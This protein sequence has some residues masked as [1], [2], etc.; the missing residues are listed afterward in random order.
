[1]PRP[2]VVVT[3]FADAY[4]SLL[5]FLYRAPV[6]VVQARMDGAIEAITPLAAQFLVP[7]SETGHPENLFAVLQ[8]HVPQLSSA[9]A[10]ATGPNAV[11]CEGLRIKVR[12]GADG[13]APQVLSLSLLKLDGREVMAVIADVTKDV[14]REESDRQLADHKMSELSA[15]LDQALATMDIALA[16]EDL[17][18]GQV[19]PNERLRA[20]LGVSPLAQGLTGADLLDRLHPDDRERYLEDRQRAIEG[21]PA[22]FR[23]FRI[24]RPGGGVFYVAGRRH[25]E[26]DSHGRPV[27]LTTFGVDVTEQRRAELERI[28]LSNR[29]RLATEAAG[30]GTFEIE[31]HSRDI[32]WNDQTYQLF[33]HRDGVR[34]E[35]RRL[36]EQALA[37]ADLL[38]FDA[39]VASVFDGQSVGTLEYA[40]IRSDGQA[41][42]LANR[43]QPQ[44]DASGAIVSMI[45]VTWDVTEQRQAAE[46]LQARRVA[47]QANRAKT[48]FLSAMSHE[49]R[50]PLH[51][52]L[53]FSEILMSYP[54]A[55]LTPSQRQ[56]VTH[57]RDSGRHLLRLI[58]DLLDVS[59]IESG[60]MAVRLADVDLRD[61]LSSALR[62]TESAARARGISVL[63]APGPAAFVRADP[64]RLRQVLLNLLTNAVK[65]NRDGGVVELQLALAADC[66]RLS[67]T[68]TGI[69]MSD[70][71][72]QRLF[73][74]FDRLGQEQTGIEGIG[75]GLVITRQLVE[76]MHGR[77]SVSSV[78]GEG[79]RFEVDL[80]A[81][82]PQP[83]A[84]RDGVPDD[85]ILVR[86]D[87]SGRVLAAEDNPVNVEV[88]RGLLAWRPGVVLEVS[89]NGQDCIEA[90][91]RCAPDLVLLDMMLPDMLGTELL[92]RLRE[93][94]EPRPLPCIFISAN[95]MPDEVPDT[96]ES[97]LNRYLTKPVSA[98]QLLAEIDRVLGARG[99]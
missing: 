31:R 99:G 4:Q 1:M 71:Q 40:V 35:P 76:A 22:P 25:L 49:L 81:C 8:P 89:E 13:V 28:A 88:L 43:G 48:V 61:I 17:V 19:F 60:K 63:L 51:A 10:Q 69:G 64:A 62:E 41:R 34:A 23:E 11:V 85:A 33:G 53:G 52:I 18:S 79:S 82:Q 45:G 24:L 46:A 14:L 29:L 91:H 47:E 2:A 30:V 90:A 9:L 59:Q 75:I 70:S 16:R 95:A 80:P 20:W 50:T 39:W 97:G 56:Q 36:L 96:A 77:L 5:R 21:H 26:H 37:P 74:P 32:T 83:D 66:W 7:L 72:I 84:Q 68:D 65:Y 3:D 12:A 87:I 67:V 42:W 78:P 73:K 93:A 27:W 58:S 55:A 44:R 57:V 38:S 98:R 92:L 6:A 86:H 54:E 15:S 94:V